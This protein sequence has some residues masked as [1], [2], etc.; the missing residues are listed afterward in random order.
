LRDEVAGQAQGAVVPLVGEFRSGAHRG[1]FN[2]VDG[3]LYVSGMAGWGT[4]TPDD[5]CFHRVRYTGKP[6]QLPQSFHVHE[7]GVLLRFTSPVDREIVSNVQNHFAQVWNYRYSSGYGSPEFSTRHPGVEGHDPLAISSVHVIDEHSIFVELPDLQPVSQLHLYL[8]V[9]RGRPQELFATVH[10][11]DKPYTK[12]PGYRPVEKIIAAHPMIVDLASARKSEPNPW[13]ARLPGARRIEIAAGKNLSFSPRVLQAR[14]GEAI[15]LVFTNPDEV[16]HNWVLIKPAALARVGD[17]TNK[18][19]AD[20]EAMLRHYVP[21]TDDVL[22]YTDIVPPR[23]SF[24]ITFRVPSEPGRYPFLCTFP[25]H[26][27]VMNGQLVVE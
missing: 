17:L 13:R 5:G 2:P 25:G 12:L 15:D 4:Y 10:R 24:R 1:R 8:Q 20:P 27:M 16:P 9:D 23:K 22:A 7:N 26:W 18:L 6:V 3:Q 21:K 14:P 19:V 11:L